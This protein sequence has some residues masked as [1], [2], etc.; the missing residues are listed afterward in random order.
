M[1]LSASH[2]A[3]VTK[4]GAGHPVIGYCELS[5]VAEQHHVWTIKGGVGVGDRDEIALMRVS[6]SCS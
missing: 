5:V 4:L 6:L 1:H 3:N 2:I